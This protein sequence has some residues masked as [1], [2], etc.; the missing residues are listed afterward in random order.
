MELEKGLEHR[1]ATE[2]CRSIPNDRKYWKRMSNAVFDDI[3]RCS[4]LD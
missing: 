1:K 4:S 2:E 3:R